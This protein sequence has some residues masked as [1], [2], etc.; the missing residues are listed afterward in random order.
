M[1]SFLFKLPIKKPKQD[2]KQANKPRRRRGGGEEEDSEG[3]N[4]RG[5]KVTI[6]EAADGLKGKEE[7]EEEER[8]V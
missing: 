4:R 3:E 6:G 1:R 2:K 7:E 8:K 5:V